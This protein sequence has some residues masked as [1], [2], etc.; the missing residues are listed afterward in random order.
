[1]H[2]KSRLVFLALHRLTKRAWTL[3]GGLGAFFS[4]KFAIST[5]QGYLS[6]MIAILKLRKDDDGP[7]VHEFAPVF[8]VNCLSGLARTKQSEV[9]RYYG[10]YLSVS[11]GDQGQPTYVTAD[12]FDNHNNIFAQK[13]L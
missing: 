10:I 1:M 9:E 8:D 3:S 5:V 12:V 6:E 2:I 11:G 7:V 4:Y 13:A